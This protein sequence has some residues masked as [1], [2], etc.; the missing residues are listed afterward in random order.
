MGIELLIR[1]L[2]RSRLLRYRISWFV[3]GLAGFY[4]A[5][6]LSFM[7]LNHHQLATSGPITSCQTQRDTAGNVTGYLFVPLGK[8]ALHL[9]LAPGDFSPQPPEVC[10][11][12]VVSLSYET[13]NLGGPLQ[14]DSIDVAHANGATTRYATA[15]GRNFTTARRLTL[16]VWGG[17]VSLL[18]AIMLLVGIFWKHAGSLVLR[19][20]RVSRSHRPRKLPATFTE[21]VSEDLLWL[22]SLPWGATTAAGSAARA[23]FER[24]LA[25]VQGWGSDEERLREGIA[26][27]V[28]C[29]PEYAYVGAA[30]TALQLAEYD[31]I[32]WAPA[33]ARA[34]LAYA[35]RAAAIAPSLAD[36]QLLRVR[37]LAA[38]GAM[39]ERGALAKADAALHL[40]RELDPTHPRVPLAV[41]ALYLARRQYTPALASLRLAL[42]LAPSEDA[43]HALHDQMA[44]ILERSGNLRQ[45]LRAFVTVSVESHM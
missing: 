10:Q 37:A 45:A 43:Q 30:E 1:W 13:A 35:E 12:F 24:G 27:L 41:A 3:C 23:Q 29:P 7:V 40:A 21:Q 5:G 11:V 8:P 42:Q 20:K 19:K 26:L 17:G 32:S 15:A 44:R 39:R 16:L 9:S 34:A 18:S 22:D 25:L 33:G 31:A 28:R 6:V 38:L 36:A 2:L 4:L 14:V